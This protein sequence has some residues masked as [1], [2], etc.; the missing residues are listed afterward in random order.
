MNRARRDR[1]RANEVKAGRHSQADH[2]PGEVPEGKRT[3]GPVNC[4]VCR[5][6][7]RRPLVHGDGDR[8]RT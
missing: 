5:P 2:K 7:S 8:W 1:Q 3:P 6:V 4:A